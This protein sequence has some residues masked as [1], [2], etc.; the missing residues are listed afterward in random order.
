DLGNQSRRKRLAKKRPGCCRWS[1]LRNIPEMIIKAPNG[2]NGKT[3]RN[4]C[5]G[6]A[7]NATTAI[8]Q[9]PLAA[10]I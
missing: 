7:W 5:G 10:E 6:T 3:Y 8:M 9:K 2:K 4:T 1:S